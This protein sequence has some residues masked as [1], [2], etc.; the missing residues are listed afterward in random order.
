[1]GEGTGG[2]AVQG[3]RERERERRRGGE[4]EERRWRTSAT[5]A[6]T[7]HATASSKPAPPLRGGGCCDAGPLPTAR[8]SSSSWR[9]SL[10]SSAS[11]ELELC[12]PDDDENWLSVSCELGHAYVAG[13]APSRVALHTNTSIEP[14]SQNSVWMCRWPSSSQHPKYCT[15][16]GHPTSAAWAHASRITRRPSFSDAIFFAMRLTAYSTPS[17][18]RRAQKMEEKVPMPMSRTCSKSLT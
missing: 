7:S 14:T 6:S 2:R 8:T 3:G 10:L 18:R 15:K 5:R 11:G 13:T 12:R 9:T 4:G 1:V 16:C 17:R